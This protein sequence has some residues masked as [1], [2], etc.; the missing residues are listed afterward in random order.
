MTIERAPVADDR[1]VRAR[2][3]EPGSQPQPAA[4]ASIPADHVVQALQQTHGNQA[5]TRMIAAHRASVQRKVSYVN[6][7]KAVAD[8]GP[9]HVEK[10]E[11]RIQKLVAQESLE[12]LKS[13]IGRGLVKIRESAIDYGVFDVDDDQH[14]MLL[15]H[16]LRRQTGST[17]PG[18]KADKDAPVT[19]QEAAAKAK[20]E[21]W[22]AYKEKAGEARKIVNTA[23]IG[24]GASIAYEVATRSPNENPADAIIIGLVQPWEQARGPGVVNHPK[25]MIDPMLQAIGDPTGING[26]WLDRGDF[27]GLID[28]VFTKSLIPRWVR[29]VKQITRE[30][31]DGEQLYRIE[32]DNTPAP[33]FARDV[34]FGAG[35]GGH[36]PPD[37][38]TPAKHE[39]AIAEN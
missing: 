5:V 27:S 1:R 16:Q 38:V 36:K 31:V 26:R 29:A 18:P 34:V 6:A 37:K 21:K 20:D 14:M 24:G 19:A 35:A 17:Q 11:Q 12:P 28:Q 2:E 3:S 10:I 22:S 30:A 33:V 4:P 15:Y 9:G 32:V 8:G 13:E 23:Y 39:G 7:G 25:H